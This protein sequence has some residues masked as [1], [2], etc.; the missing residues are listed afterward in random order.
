MEYLPVAL[1]VLTVVVFVAKRV[2]KRTKTT[3]D[4]KVVALVE[5]YGPAAVRAA[6]AKLDKP[7]PK[8]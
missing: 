7:E 5:K 4:D 1:A 6:F 8:A 3:V 2:V